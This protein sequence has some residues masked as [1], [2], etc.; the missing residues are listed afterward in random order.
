MPAAAGGSCGWPPVGHGSRGLP[1]RSWGPSRSGTAKRL[2][3]CW[4][5]QRPRPRRSRD[6]TRG[7]KGAT[8]NRRALLCRRHPVQ[9]RGSDPGGYVRIKSPPVRLAGDGGGAGGDFFAGAFPPQPKTIGTDRARRVLRLSRS[10]RTPGRQ[11][12]WTARLANP[13]A[14]PDE[15]ALTCRRCPARQ[16]A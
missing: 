16:S 15:L 5:V 10:G 2:I 3:A 1:F 14:R 8:P 11:R 7:R 12:R 13:L 4:A 6:G 9:R